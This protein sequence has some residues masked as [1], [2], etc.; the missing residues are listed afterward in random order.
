MPPR[1]PTSDEI[2]VHQLALTR[3][4]V[5][6]VDKDISVI[7]PD[8][9]ARINAMNFLTGLGLFKVLQDKKQVQWKVMTK[10]EMD[11]KKDLSAEENIV[12]GHIS[13]SENKGIWTK[14]LKVKTDLHQTVL[15]RCLKSL[16]SKGLVKTVKSV[17]HSTRKIYMLAH[18][19]PSI[20]L[21]G[22]PWYTD[23]ELDV[24]FIRLLS[25]AC[26]YYIKECSFPPKKKLKSHNK[27]AMFSISSAPKYPSAKDVLDKLSKTKVST[28]ELNLEDVESLLNVLV[29]DGEVEKVP[30]FGAA[31]WD[32]TALAELSD[33]DEA[34]DSDDGSSKKKKKKSSSS[35]RSKRKRQDDSTTE[36]SDSDS[37]DDRRSKSRSS[38]RSKSKSKSRKK[39]KEYASSTDDE[40]SDNEGS[41]K[42]KK[43]KDTKKSKKSKRDNDDSGSDSDSE[44]DEEESKRKK[45]KK[46]KSSHKDSD[47]SGSDSPPPKRKTKTKVKNEP[48]SPSP[49]DIAGLG[50]STSAAYVYRAIHQEKISSLGFLQAPCSVCPVFEFCKDL[51]PTNPGECEYF[52][53]WLDHSLAQ[54][55]EGLLTMDEGE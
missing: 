54:S 43:K 32:A 37:E 38:S 14:Q 4:E 24:E 22:G 31:M 36:V 21:T 47:S 40:D 46:R 33:S 52:G 28:T 5:P 35:S 16:T 12:F 48:R 20:E 41:R 8:A 42:R 7:I 29:L 34:S 11:M 23:N 50:F 25:N 10:Q 49:M 39:R 55:M 2:K 19:E 44:S 15:D 27:N 6:L 53:T 26:L 13:A 18:L 9:Q 30:A 51:G 1:K 45:K 17:Q 3:P